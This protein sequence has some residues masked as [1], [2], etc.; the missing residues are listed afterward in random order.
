M[1][2][3]AKPRMKPRIAARLNSSRVMKARRTVFARLW[4][5]IMAEKS[6]ARVPPDP[7]LQLGQMQT[8]STIRKVIASF[9]NYTCDSLAALKPSDKG[10]YVAILFRDLSVAGIPSKQSFNLLLNYKSLR[11][12]HVISREW[13]K[14]KKPLSRMS[15]T[16]YLPSGC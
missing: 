4:F 11:F 9:G 14:K 7:R 8:R 2:T 12:F 5:K 1:I 6:L 13:H 3:N 15:I 10:L 16:S